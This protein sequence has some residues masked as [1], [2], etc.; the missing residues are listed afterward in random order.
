MLRLFAFAIITT[1]SLDVCWLDACFAQLT[2]TP[3]VTNPIINPPY[4]GS[5]SAKMWTYRNGTDIDSRA[6]AFRIE[7]TFGE[8]LQ[9]KLSM[10][11]VKEIEG[12]KYFEKKK[13]K[14]NNTSIDAFTI[15]CTLEPNPKKTGYLIKAQ[16]SQGSLAE[17]GVLSTTP[18]GKFVMIR[19]HKENVTVEGEPTPIRNPCE[20]PPE[21]G[22]EELV[23]IGIDGS[24][25]GPTL[26][27]T[28]LLQPDSPNV[29]SVIAPN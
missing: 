3:S 24:T 29:S 12:G 28:R 18:D 1:L 17:I 25:P 6:L 15:D 7:G 21:I 22:E 4:D 2:P 10:Y 23:A 19:W 5:G 11:K 13:L 8:N 20:E 14:V 16:A 27:I 26:T 9:G